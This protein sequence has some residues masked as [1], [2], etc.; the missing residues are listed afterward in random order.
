MFLAIGM[1]F[2]WSFSMT[3]N[4]VVPWAN[5]VTHVYDYVPAKFTVEKMYYKKRDLPKLPD[6]WEVVGAVGN[7]QPARIVWGSLYKPPFEVLNEDQFRLAFQEGQQF[8]VLINRSLDYKDST[9]VINYRPDFPAGAKAVLGRCLVY[10]YGN[11]AVT[12]ALLLGWYWLRK[13]KPPATR[14]VGSDKMR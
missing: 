11:L 1:Q 9:R 12:A 3:M 2:V 6:T 5:V 14:G 7:N 8:D 13:K 10:A 4:K